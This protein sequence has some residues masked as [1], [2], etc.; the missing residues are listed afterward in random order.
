MTVAHRSEWGMSSSKEYR[1]RAEARA[2]KEQYA[3]QER[4]RVQEREKAQAQ[5][6]E[7]KTARLKTLRLAKEAA[8]RCAAEPA[9]TN[10]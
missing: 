3:A 2:R 6:V 1:E 5:A 7:E 9:T 4:E 8:D 10:T